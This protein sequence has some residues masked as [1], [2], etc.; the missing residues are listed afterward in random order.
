MSAFRFGMKL[1]IV[2]VLGLCQ[3]MNYFLP[4]LTFNSHYWVS[5]EVAGVESQRID[6]YTPGCSTPTASFTLC[7]QPFPEAS[8]DTGTIFFRVA[9]HK[10]S[11]TI[12]ISIYHS[13]Y[14]ELLFSMRGY[15]K[16]NR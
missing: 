3:E 12:Y 4:A 10:S 1:F 13:L 6:F 5:V 11:I 2:S 15:S 9:K 14:G 16:H 8:I 7:M